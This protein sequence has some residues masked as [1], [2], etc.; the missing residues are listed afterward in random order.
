MTKFIMLF[1]LLSGRVQEADNLY[2][3]HTETATYDFACEGEVL[4]WIETGTFTYDDFLCE[5]GELE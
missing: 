3:V 5:C 4:R 1:Y 2:V